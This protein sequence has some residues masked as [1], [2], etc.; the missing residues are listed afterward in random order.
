[1]KLI[2]YLHTAIS[3]LK[4]PTKRYL[5]TKAYS[6]KGKHGLEIGGPSRFFHTGSFFPI[7]V[8]AKQID[9][10]NYS[11]ETVWEGTLTEGMTYQY[12]KNKMGYQYVQE[13]TELSNIQNNQYDFVLSCHSL[14]HVAN[15]IKA[16]FE[17]KRVLKKGGLLML[18]LPFKE[19]TFDHKRPYTDFDH[20]VADYLNGTS[21]KD[22]THFPE[23]ISLHDLSKEQQ[24]ID[25]SAFIKRLNDNYVNR[26]AHHHVFCE[27]VVAQML[28][29]TGY[30]LDY[31]IIVHKFHLIALAY[32]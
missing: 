25:K 3:Y 28:E 4:Q 15:P 11:S 12:F 22:D 19:S 5:I 7:Y 29:Y 21:E 9:V 8:F 10:A 6:L 27:K 1:M 32:S 13:A 24:T 23:I 18:I 14:E 17:W 16:L 2:S 30:K 20:L 26:C 31:Q